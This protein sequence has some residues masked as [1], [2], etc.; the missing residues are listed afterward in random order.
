MQIEV[1]ENGIQA[2]RKIETWQA[3]GTDKKHIFVFAYDTTRSEDLTHFT[4]T[5]HVGL[6]ELRFEEVF[7]NL[8]RDRTQVLHSKLTAIG[9]PV[10]E[11]F[12]LEEKMKDG[13][14]VVIRTH[15][16]P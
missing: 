14:V 15:P 9:V 10:K 5:E 16:S 7:T 4:D 13:C 6:G 8:F 11:A 1:V 2:M 12:T 3:E